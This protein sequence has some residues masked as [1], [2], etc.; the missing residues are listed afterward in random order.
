MKLGHEVQ[1]MALADARTAHDI[2]LNRLK[3]FQSNGDSE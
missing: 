3:A 2:H 1:D